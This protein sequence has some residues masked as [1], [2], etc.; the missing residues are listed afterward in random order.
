MVAFGAHLD[1]HPLAG[2]EDLYKFLHQAVYGP[3]HAIPNPEAA[4]AWMDREL[5]GLGLPLED[6]RVCEA[7][8]GEPPLVRIN[9]RPFVAGGG[10]PDLL[11]AEFVVS[12]NLER[13]NSHRME[14]VLSMAASYVQCAGHG[15]LSPELEALNN[16]LA[17]QGYPAIH[18]SEA[19]L[20]AYRPAYR[21]VEK[22][23]AAKHGWCT[24]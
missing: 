10:D 15:D 3:G 1:D 21:V 24:E 4:A 12:A 11:V 8:G 2:S 17:A 19:Y 7:L 16:E 6:E 9:L 18:H 5:A 20:E 14:V 23:L 13:G 22:A